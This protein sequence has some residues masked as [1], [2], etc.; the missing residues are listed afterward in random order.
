MD[1]AKLSEEVAEDQLQIFFDYYDIDADSGTEEQKKAIETAHKKLSRAIQNGLLTITAENGV[2][3]TQILRYP[4]GDCSTITY[5]KISGKSRV[6]MKE[7]GNEYSRMY[8]LLAT[9]AGLP[10]NAI[11]ALQGQDISVAEYLAVLF[12]AV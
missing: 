9:L 6:A 3:V 1:K 2:T 11:V 10:M 5:N 4:P 7:K 8:S 12:L